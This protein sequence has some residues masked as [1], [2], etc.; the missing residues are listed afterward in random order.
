[1]IQMIVWIRTQLHG[2]LVSTIIIKSIFFGSAKN[3]DLHGT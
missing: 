1:M 3:P 2:K